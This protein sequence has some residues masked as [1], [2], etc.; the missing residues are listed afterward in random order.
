MCEN[1][2]ASFARLECI[3]FCCS[4]RV[5][6]GEASRMARDE[7]GFRIYVSENNNSRSLT[8]GFCGP[9]TQVHSSWYCEYSV[10]GSWASLACFGDGRYFML[11]G[12][13]EL[14]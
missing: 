7:H 11:V 9:G 10:A 2:A 8:T 14:R 3:G 6:G 4:G 12:L 1:P 5:L 13:S